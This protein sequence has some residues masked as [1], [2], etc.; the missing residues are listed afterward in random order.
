MG[1]AGGDQQEIGNKKEQHECQGGG[2]KLG[3]GNWGEWEGGVQDAKVQHEEL[4]V[5]IIHLQLKLFRYFCRTQ[6]AHLRQI[7][8]DHV[9][10]S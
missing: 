4:D 5:E 10:L 7:L 1:T 2:R 8:R 3:D 6:I 9:F